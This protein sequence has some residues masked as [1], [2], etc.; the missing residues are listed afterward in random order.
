MEPEMAN[1]LDCHDK[2]I[3]RA[4][5]AWATRLAVAIGAGLVG[6]HE[7]DEAVKSWLKKV[8]RWRQP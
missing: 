1:V 2:E 8:T 7:A 5:D 6:A 3:Q 4:A